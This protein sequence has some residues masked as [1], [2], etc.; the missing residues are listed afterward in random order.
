MNALTD[1]KS[2]DIIDLNMFKDMFKKYDNANSD[3]SF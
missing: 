3:K 1:G 2:E